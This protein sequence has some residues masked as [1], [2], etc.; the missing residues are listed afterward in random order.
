MNLRRSQLVE[1]AELHQLT[2]DGMWIFSLIDRVDGRERCRQWRVG[3]DYMS[4]CDDERRYEEVATVHSRLNELFPVDT[5]NA[6]AGI[7]QHVRRSSARL[8]RAFA[9]VALR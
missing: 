7:I 3:G 4:W 1:A 2:T 9:S 6:S 5:D 8:K